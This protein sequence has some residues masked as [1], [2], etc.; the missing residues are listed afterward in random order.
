MPLETDDV[1]QNHVPGIV[2]DAIDRKILA[3][4]VQ[5]AKQTNAAIGQIA[6]LSAPAVH[7]RI[8]RL[9]RQGVISGTVAL[10]NGAAVGKPLL[11]F[12]HVDADGWG[13]SQ[14]MMRLAD[15][16]E[17]EEIHSVAGDTSLILKVRTASPDALEHFL[18][19]LYVLPGVR[20]TK[21]FVV[22]STY[23]ERVTQAEVTSDWPA[24]PMPPE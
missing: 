22:L 21:S 8:K 11:S 9:C 15:F 2:L 3:A 20:A 6:G 17:V 14:R 24:I 5:D 19:Q 10:L 1:K 7:E 12:V 4:L 18:S 16:P 23:E 13:K